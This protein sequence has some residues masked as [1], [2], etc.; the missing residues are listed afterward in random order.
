MD[1]LD[2]A[3]R[4]LPESDIKTALADMLTPAVIRLQNVI[5]APCLICVTLYL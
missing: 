3:D 5:F 4:A 2:H 1:T